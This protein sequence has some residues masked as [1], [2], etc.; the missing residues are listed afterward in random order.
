MLV[1]LG[2]EL[3]KFGVD[4]IILVKGEEL[5]TKKFDRS[6]PLFVLTQ[7]KIISGLKK[8]GEVFE[9]KSSRLRDQFYEVLNLFNAEVPK[10]SLNSRCLVSARLIKIE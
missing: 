2:K 8:Y 7:R 10:M 5:G 1:E 6:G 4:T 9:V 3:R